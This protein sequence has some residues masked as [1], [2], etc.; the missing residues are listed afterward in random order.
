MITYLWVFSYCFYVFQEKVDPPNEC[1]CYFRHIY[2]DFPS[3]IHTCIS[4]NI[5]KILY[6]CKITFVTT[7]KLGRD[8][9]PLITHTLELGRIVKPLTTHTYHVYHSTKFNMSHIFFP[10][11]IRTYHVYRSTKFS[12]YNIFISWQRFLIVELIQH[13]YYHQCH[14]YSKA[15][16][17]NFIYK[18]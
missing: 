17:D 7:S 3:K 9:K 13:N 11:H 1:F 15:Y 6:F 18:L 8:I 4:R 14:E 10:G 16:R 12:I 2:I 5:I